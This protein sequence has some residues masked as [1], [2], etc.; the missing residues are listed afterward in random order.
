MALCGAIFLGFCCFAI[1]NPVIPVVILDAGGDAFVVGLLVAAYS[2]PSVLLRPFM[3]RLVDEWSR[4]RV[5]L[6]GAA[7]LGLSSFLY[8]IPG[9]G[10]M[11]VTRLFSGSS[12]AAFNTSGNA[13]LATLAPSSRRAEAAAIYNLMPSL[14]Y[15]IAPAVGLLLLGAVGA[16]AAFVAAGL[17]GLGSALL[18]A[19]GPLRSGSPQPAPARPGTWRT[20]LERR[21]LLP[22]SI[23]FLWVTTNVLFF[24]FPPVWADE[25][26]IPVADLTLYYPIVG[27]ALVVSRVVVGLNLDR[28]SRG[29]AI[30]AGM[31][32]GI[33][34]IGLALVADSVLLLTVAGATFAASSSLVSPTAAA[35]AIDRADPQRRGA[36]MATYSMGFPLGNGFGAVLWGTLIALLGFPA[37]FVV[38]LLTMGAIGWLV[39]S[40]RD[41]LLV[42][43]GGA[44]A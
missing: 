26:G 18:V 25:R 1:V 7:G 39:W 32:G 42:R 35:I 19:F 37:P 43:A 13:T 17:L 31:T 44:G 40:A 9:L 5:L 3:G 22:M 8:L 16:A 14:A 15:M 27:A 20:L 41:Q 36:S 21:A 30:L 34:A 11:A 33:V 4:W 29:A 6:F 10:P 24:I 23:E 38:A 28:W 2:I 12:F